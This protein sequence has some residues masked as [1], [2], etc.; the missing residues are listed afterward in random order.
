MTILGVWYFLAG[1]A[2]LAPRFPRLKAWAYAGLAFNYTGAVASHLAVG[3]A[4]AALAGPILFLVL[5]TASWALRSSARQPPS[6]VG[7]GIVRP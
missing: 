5:V 4:A 7:P 3:D 1:F 2:L 6:S